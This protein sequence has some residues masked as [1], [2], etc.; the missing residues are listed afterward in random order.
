MARSP[1]RSSISNKPSGRRE[2]PRS[3]WKTGEQPLRQLRGGVAMRQRTSPWRTNVNN[4][5]GNLTQ[6]HPTRVA[7]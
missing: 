7:T 4:R 5:T 2:P 3:L 1:D 6:K